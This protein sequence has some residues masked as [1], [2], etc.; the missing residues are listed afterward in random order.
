M[1]QLTLISVENIV[2]NPN[3]PRRFFNEEELIELAESIKI[4]GLLQ[5]PLVRPL[6]DNRY[7]LVAGERRFRASK[8]AG[9]KFINVIIEE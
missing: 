1:Q 7:E 6:G 8:I 9:L 5:P 3:Q 2:I 4:N